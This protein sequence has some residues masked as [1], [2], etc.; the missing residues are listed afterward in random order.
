MTTPVAEVVWPMHVSNGTKRD[1]A[2]CLIQGADVTETQQ[3]Q[4][5][6]CNKTWKR[7]KA[8]DSLSLNESGTSSMGTIS[9]IMEKLDPVQDANK[10]AKRRNAIAKGKNTVGYDRYCQLVPK[11]SR[12]PRCLETPSTPNATVDVPNRR[13]LGMVRAWYV[14]EC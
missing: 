9:T 13:W 8:Y 12:R 3:H 14:K 6:Y 11:H 10:I 1:A 7:H 2:D 4:Q 5:Q